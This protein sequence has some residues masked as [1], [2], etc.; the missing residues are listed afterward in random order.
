M[1]LTVP[2]TQAVSDLL[3]AQLQI[4]FGQTIPFLPKSFIR[5]MAKVWAGVFVLLYKY[6]GFIFLQM[7]VSRASSESTEINGINLVP[8]YEWGALIGVGRPNAATQAEHTCSVVVTSLGG[9]LPVGTPLVNKKTGYVYVTENA[10][11][12]TTNPVTITVRANSDGAGGD[13]SG[14]GGNL[15]NGDKLSFANA[16]PNVLRECTVT[17]Q[18]VTGAAAENIDIYRAR[19]IKRFNSR[20]QGGAYADYHA[21]ATDVPGIVAA[22]PYTGLLPG[23]VDVYVEASIDSSGSPDGIPTGPQLAA[24]AEAFELD[25]DGLATR[26]PVNAAVNALA[27]ARLG[28]SV[29]VQGLDAPDLATT[30]DAITTSIDSYLREAEPYIVGLSVPPRKDRVTA[31]AI[32]GIVDA[33]V[34]ANFGVFT[35]VILKNG[36]NPLGQYTVTRGQKLKLSS[37]TFPGT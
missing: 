22:Y 9:S 4:S 8:L 17:G 32:G 11:P 3:I 24:V 37:I 19:V 36:V 14:P 26:R 18:N 13:G 25:E 31:G 27:I 30:K 23:E 12:L 33:V 28:L 7:F 6:G 29:E 20:P 34:N 15:A 35:G 1:S 16:L 5:V 2:N 10:V 21:W